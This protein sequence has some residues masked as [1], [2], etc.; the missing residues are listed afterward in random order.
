MISIRD[1]VQEALQSG[2]LTVEAENQLRQLLCKKYDL[3]DMNAFV[4]LQAA[5]MSGYVK[6]QSRESIA[7]KNCVS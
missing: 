3:E 1:L 4:N 6:Q 5:A 7:A 2:Y